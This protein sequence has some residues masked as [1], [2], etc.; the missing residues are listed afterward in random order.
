MLKEK[1]SLSDKTLA[2][3]NKRKDEVEHLWGIIGQA[4]ISGNSQ[5]YANSAKGL[6]DQMMWVAL[7]IM[8]LVASILAIT[9]ILDLINGSFNYLH[10]I[11]KIIG[12]TIFLIPSFYCSNISKRHRDREFQ[13]RDFE[14]KTA[15]LE[16]FLENMNLENSSS[17]PNEISKDKI[18]LELTKS[19]FDKQFDNGTNECV[20]LPKEISKIL[21]TLAKKCNLSINLGN[22]DE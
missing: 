8:V 22:K 13:L 12:S 15:A 4:A 9:T 6:A 19:F 10:F 11:Y 18:K 17:D 7:G 2:F 3:L 5:N 16:P 14:V 21:N 20:L 1:E